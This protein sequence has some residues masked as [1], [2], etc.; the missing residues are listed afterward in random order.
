MDTW[1]FIFHIWT[2]YASHLAPQPVTILK[3]KTC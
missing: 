1:L 2:T 3:L